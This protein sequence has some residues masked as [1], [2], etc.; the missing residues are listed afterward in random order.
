[1]FQ[2]VGKCNFKINVVPKTIK[3]YMSF[4]I[5]Q[6]K[7]EGIKSGLLLVFINSVYFLDNLV[8]NLG[9]ND[10]YHLSQEFNAKEKR[11]FTMTTWIALKIPKKLKPKRIDFITH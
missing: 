10:F 3:K 8:K 6:S 9:E 11:F 4:T 2:E 1:M 7:K 5:K